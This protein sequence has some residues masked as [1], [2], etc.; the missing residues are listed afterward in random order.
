MPAQDM[1]RGTAVR[2]RYV[3]QTRKV[4]RRLLDQEM[5]CLGQD[6]RREAG[7]LLL[8]H[9][10]VRYRPPEGQQGSSAYMQ[11]I[12]P[13]KRLVVWG[14]GLFFGDTALG[15]LHLRRYDFAPRYTP[16]STLALP[17]WSPEQLPAT[18]SPREV[19]E[20]LRV[21]QLLTMA[22]TQLSRYEDWVQHTQ[23]LTYRRACVNSWH[24]A[25]SV[26]AEL[27]PQTWQTLAAQCAAAQIW[28]VKEEQPHG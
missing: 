28:R 2:L 21:R 7:N 25:A 15:G 3:A 22:F 11:E 14:W 5:W 24:R 8:Q 19:E 13:A 9:G 17:L 10:F 27:M 6:I 26:S 20:C 4:A 12:D 23:G 18:N 1:E 16:V